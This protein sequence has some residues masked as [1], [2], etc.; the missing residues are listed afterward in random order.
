M[1]KILKNIDSKKTTQLGD[2]PIRIIKEIKFT[3]SKILSKMFNFYIDS[4]TFPNGLNDTD[5][6]KM[7]YSIQCKNGC[8]A[9]SDLFHLFKQSVKFYTFYY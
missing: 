9:A 1:L 6:E 4:N 2:I 7:F 5:R 3:F 8:L